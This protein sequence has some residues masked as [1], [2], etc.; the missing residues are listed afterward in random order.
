MIYTRSKTRRGGLKL[1]QSDGF[2]YTVHTNREAQSGYIL[3]R[4][5]VRGKI[6]GKK[7]SALLTQRGETYTLSAGGHSCAQKP[8]VDV[9]SKICNKIKELACSDI[10]RSTRQIVDSVLLEELGNGKC[11]ANVPNISNLVRI[12]RRAH[13]GSLPDQPQTLQFDR[14]RFGSTV[15]T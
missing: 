12:A 13:Y 9:S 11:S 4:C 5:A 6:E 10:T 1:V 3:W 7:C 2:A 15:S 14:N 8:G